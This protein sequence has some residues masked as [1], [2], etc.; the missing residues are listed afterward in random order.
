MEL[1][2]PAKTPHNKSLQPTAES[3][4]LC[5][6]LVIVSGFACEMGL[7]LLGGG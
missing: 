7:G 1:I 2:A 6:V 5:N 4:R 3:P